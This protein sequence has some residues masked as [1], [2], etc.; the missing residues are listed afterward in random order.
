MFKQVIKSFVISLIDVVAVRKSRFGFGINKFVLDN[1]D[2]RGF[3]D[4][5]FVCQNHYRNTH[6]CSLAESAG[7]RCGGKSYLTQ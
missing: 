5:L 6:N 3:E 1:L 2:C 7:V 4:N